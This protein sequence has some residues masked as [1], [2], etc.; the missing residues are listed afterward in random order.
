MSDSAREGQEIVNIH[1]DEV[2]PEVAERVTNRLAKEEGEWTADRIQSYVKESLRNQY[3]S[4]L[5]KRHPV[6]LGEDLPHLSVKA[7]ADD[8]IEELATSE[9]AEKYLCWRESLPVPEKE[10][11]SLYTGGYTNEAAAKQLGM[12]LTAYKDMKMR[13]VR[14]FEQSTGVT[15]PQI[16]GAGPG[17]I[18]AIPAFLAVALQPNTT[19]STY[20]WPQAL[21]DV[22]LI[23]AF[24]LFRMATSFLFSKKSA[25]GPALWSSLGTGIRLF[26]RRDINH[27]TGSCVRTQALSLFFVPVLALR[28]YRIPKD[29]A[30]GAMTLRTPLSRWARRANL[31]GCAFLVA[32]ALALLRFVHT[33]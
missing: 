14:S 29:I 19:K 2:W 9:L 22:A 1:A 25:Q 18:A 11:W 4:Q 12:G 16:R 10:V 15:L 26:G 7:G 27:N 31:F 32:E 3:V 17:S 21:R 23:H 33:P 28:A 13:V 24:L 5:K 6:L 30:P 20:S 8:V